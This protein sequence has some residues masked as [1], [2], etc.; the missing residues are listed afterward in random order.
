MD[1]LMRSASE[2]IRAPLDLWLPASPGDY[3]ENPGYLKFDLM[4]RGIRVSETL[5]QDL[6]VRP[7]KDSA[8]GVG[9]GIDLL[10]PEDVW[11]NTPV[12]EPFV[13][14]SPYRLG[15]D[16]DG[17]RVVIDPPLD[18]FA[19]RWVSVGVGP[20]PRVLEKTLSTG[21]RTSAVVALQ[22]ELLI[23][24]IGNREEYWNRRLSSRRGE[25]LD[26]SGAEAPSV[27]EALEI[28]AAAAEE[29][30]GGDVYVNAGLS[31]EPDGG[32]RKVEPYVQALKRHF[33]PLVRLAASP[34]VEEAW[35][36]HAYAIGVDSIAYDIEVFDPRTFR[37]VAPGRAGQIGRD[38]Y[39]ERLS[40]A[41]QV[42]PNGAVT[43]QLILGLEPLAESLKG[44]SA[45]CELG[46]LPLLSV[47]R[48]LQ[49]TGLE[50]WPT[51][52][53][54]SVAPVVA[55]LF[56]CARRHGIGMIWGRGISNE[57]TPLEARFFT[58]ED[59]TAQVKRSKFYRSRAGA[60]VARNLA[61]LR[62]ALRVRTVRDSFDS[63]GL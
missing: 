56:H 59:A 53:T 51:V 4:T 11:V 16:D 7:V 37:E 12:R 2:M 61:G 48:P 46:V 22:G 38:R 18:E 52:E 15:R 8:R 1:E 35:V 20:K 10:L 43:S 36:D 63:A 54:I 27:A 25:G 58:T 13:A 45:L 29:G 9:S 24:D 6:H 39:L 55:F 40:R 60:V 50:D 30:F 44:I 14:S 21:R 34:P 23:L 47:F 17:W 26:L 33:N 32:L 42:F 5:L 49:G 28:V 41:A 57:M 19:G 3:I 31:L 62:R